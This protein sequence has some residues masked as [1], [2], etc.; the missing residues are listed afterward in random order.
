MGQSQQED[1]T[2]LNIYVPDIGG[3]QINKTTT[4]GAHVLRTS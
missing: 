3:T 1:T 4:T 2:I